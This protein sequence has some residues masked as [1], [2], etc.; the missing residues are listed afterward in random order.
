MTDR[1]PVNPFLAMIRGVGG[2]SRRSAIAG[3]KAKAKAR[4]RARNKAGARM[5]AR[6]R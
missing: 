5:R 4:R 6:Q 1:G 2:K 3:H